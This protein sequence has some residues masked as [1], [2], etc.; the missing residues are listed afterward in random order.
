MS[1]EKVVAA[2]QSLAESTPEFLEGQE[3]GKSTYSILC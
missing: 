2:L 1:Q 3:T